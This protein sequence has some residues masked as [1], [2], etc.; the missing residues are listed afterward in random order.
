MVSAESVSKRRR[1]VCRVRNLPIQTTQKQTP[2][3]RKKKGHVLCSLLSEGYRSSFDV[4]V[5]TVHLFLTVSRPQGIKTA[6]KR[7]QFFNK[8]RMD[9]SWQCPH[10]FTVPTCC[11]YW[12]VFYASLKHIST[13]LIR[14]RPMTRTCLPTVDA[15][16]LPTVDAYIMHHQHTVCP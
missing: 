6:C 8:R 11:R 1:D 3:N 14:T 2:K 4:C 12:V 13:Q 16:I 7:L 5:Y 9:D 15:Y 10:V